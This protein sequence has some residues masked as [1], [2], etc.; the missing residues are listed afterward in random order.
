MSTFVNMGTLVTDDTS[1][2]T[3]THTIYDGNWQPPWDS[4]G[5]TSDYYRTVTRQWWRNGRLR[6]DS[7]YLKVI[8]EWKSFNGT[9]HN[10]RA[11]LGSESWGFGSLGGLS[12]VDPPVSTSWESADTKALLKLKSGGSNV[13]VFF[14]ESNK[15]LQMLSNRFNQIANLAHRAAMGNPRNWGKRSKYYRHSPPNQNR[16]DNAWLELQYGWL[17]LFQDI[18]GIISALAGNLNKDVVRV[19]GTSHDTVVAQSVS[20]TSTEESLGTLVNRTRKSGVSTTIQ[21]R[22]NSA[23]LAY[24]AALGLTNPLYVAWELIPF[25]FVW[26][27][28]VPVGN[29]LEALDATSGWTFVDGSHTY[30]ENKEYYVYQDSFQRAQVVDWYQSSGFGYY[31]RFQMQRWKL[32]GFPIPEFPGFKNPL[33]LRHSLNALALVKQA[34]HR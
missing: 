23:P 25:S 14:A 13:A 34:F 1:V 18:D 22:L 20:K 30:L 5:T 26:D 9:W 16:I 11:T 19:K 24:S 17:P 8:E 10:R 7:S 27:W 15:S 2:G 31:K 33:S 21:A 28:F 32:G 3:E 4:T 12:F 6:P 29:F